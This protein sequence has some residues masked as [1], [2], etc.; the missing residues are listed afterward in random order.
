M[1]KIS[2]LIIL[3]LS[4]GVMFGQLKFGPKLGYNASTL[5]TNLDTIQ[6]SYKSGFQFGAFV[7]FGDRFYLQPELYYST[8][9]GVFQKDSANSYWKQSINI[10]SVDIPVLIGFKI[11]NTEHVNLRVMAG[12]ALSFVVN[13]KITNTGDLTG[14]IEKADINSVNWYIQAGGG[15]DI[16]MFTLDVRY[17]IGLNKIIKEVNYE[18]GSVN[19]NTANNVWIVSL[20]LKI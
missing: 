18:G 4:S 3:V 9:G 19:F 5:T 15:I 17:Q 8:H 12:P 16:W 1:K 10:G 14:P 2:L 13:K 20:G 6:T 11:L 7:R